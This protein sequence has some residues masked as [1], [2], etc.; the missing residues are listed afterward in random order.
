MNCSIYL[1]KIFYEKIENLNKRIKY[2]NS[3]Q[4]RTIPVIPSENVIIDR[5]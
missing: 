4:M 3:I 5:K 1:N 2:I